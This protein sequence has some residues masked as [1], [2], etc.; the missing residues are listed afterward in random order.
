MNTIIP[1]SWTNEAASRNEPDADAFSH[2]NLLQHDDDRRFFPFHGTIGVSPCSPAARPTMMRS[3]LLFFLSSLALVAC[4][5]QPLAVSAADWAAF[6]T[7]FVSPEGRIIDTGQDGASHSEGQ[8]Y[9][10]LLAE[11]AGDRA[12]FDRIWGWTRANLPRRPDGLFSWKWLPDDP[13]HVPDPN[14]A[15]D[16]DLLIAWALSRAADRWPDGPYRADARKL[17]SAIRR[18]AVIDSPFGAVLLPGAEGFRHG[19]RLVLNLSYWVF[20]A[21]SALDRIDSAPAWQALIGS[22]HRL[23]ALGRF[24]PHALPADW[25]QLERT[26]LSPAQDEPPR[27]GFEAVR[28][29]LY[30]CWHQWK[31]VPSLNGLAEFW[32]PGKTTIPAWVELTDNAEAPY[33]LSPGGE[34]VRRLF[35]ECQTGEAHPATPSSEPGKADTDYYSSVL[36]L[37]AEMARQEGSR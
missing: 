27:F 37:L 22:G 6:R 21:L 35:L 32:Q 36:T 7:A 11:T 23:L 29:P 2:R 14:N 9:G 15:T 33:P 8:G 24:G 12:D 26:T 3:V 4:R 13:A 30:A 20:P 18:H 16:G 17:A 10:M 1:T 19:E 31:A 34:A 25:L 28:I 5:Q